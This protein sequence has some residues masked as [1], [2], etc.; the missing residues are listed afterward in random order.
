MLLELDLVGSSLG[1]QLKTK[2]APLSESISSPQFRRKQE[3]P[4]SS[5]PSLTDG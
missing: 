3:G 1:T 4:T 5:S 2:A